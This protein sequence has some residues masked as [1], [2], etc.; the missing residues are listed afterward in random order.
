MGLTI[1][2]LF[3]CAGPSPAEASR[4]LTSFEV[5]KGPQPV[6]LLTSFQK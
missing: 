2:S 6:T 4:A 1:K 5:A 3:S